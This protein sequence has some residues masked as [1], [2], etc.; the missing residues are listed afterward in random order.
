MLQSGSVGQI[1]VMNAQVLHP[2]SVFGRTAGKQGDLS[3]ADNKHDGIPKFATS[4]ESD[5]IEFCCAGRAYAQ[6]KRVVKIR[7]EKVILRERARRIARLA[8]IE[9]IS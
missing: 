1:S 9:L 8:V 4:L 2:A 7:A 6:R 3:S 5:S